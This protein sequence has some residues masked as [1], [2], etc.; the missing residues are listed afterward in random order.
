[1]PVIELP[2]TQQ[3]DPSMAAT[4]ANVL[5]VLVALTRATH[6]RLREAMGKEPKELKQFNDSV[7]ETMDS[8]DEMVSHLVVMLRELAH[9]SADE[10]EEK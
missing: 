6:I 5:Q 4:V 1:M 8:F 3:F 10:E 7:A 2:P 9:K